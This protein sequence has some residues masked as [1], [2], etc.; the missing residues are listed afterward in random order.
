[1]NKIRKFRFAK[2]FK[3]DPNDLENFPL[4]TIFTQYS[5]PGSDQPD[6]LKSAIVDFYSA[7]RI[8]RYIHVANIFALLVVLGFYLSYT[9]TNPTS[10]EGGIFFIYENA[11]I[12]Q[13]Y[14][15]PH[16]ID[17]MLINSYFIWVPSIIFL[18]TAIVLQVIPIFRDMGVESITEDDLIDPNPSWERTKER[19]RYNGNSNEDHYVT[20]LLYGQ[21]WYGWLCT[22][23]VGT[24]ILMMIC[25]IA[26]IQ[27]LSVLIGIVI[28]HVMIT[29][30]GAF[31]HELT[32]SYMTSF[33]KFVGCV[34]SEND[35]Y[36]LNWWPYLISIL[37]P[38]CIVY[39]DIIAHFVGKILSTEH[40]SWFLWA[41]V[42][43]ITSL[44]I[45]LELALIPIFH[46]VL[47]PK[48]CSDLFNSLKK[49][50]TIEPNTQQQKIAF[51]S[52]KMMIQFN[53]SY[54][55]TKI[56][57]QSVINISFG[58]FLTIFTTIQ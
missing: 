35:K 30:N 24:I 2:L 57:L 41:S 14:K 46:Y 44:F 19:Q 55:I 11:P 16:Q 56:I 45:L 12:F 52:E 31:S 47:L 5:S 49:S 17:P 7:R 53:A 13:S 29:T 4:F 8:I 37:I 28:L 1:M 38:G 36:K 15:G 58:V 42:L 51:E 10:F 22:G 26:G 25:Q 33:D 21:G 40:P 9:F 39:G 27:D 43:C 34:Q 6:H 48:K 23:L 54:E 50:N 32:N 20:I 18:A 3:D